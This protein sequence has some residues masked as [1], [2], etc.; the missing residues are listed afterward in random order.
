MKTVLF[1][2]QNGVGGAERMT[3]NIA[4]LLPSDKWKKIFC[5]ISFPCEVQNGRIDDFFPGGIQII[6]IYWSNQISFLRQMWKVL[7]IFKPDY[8]FSSVMPYNQRLLLLA[9]FFRNIKFIVRNDN[10]TFTINRIKRIIMGF[11]YRHASSIIAQTEEMKEELEKLGINPNKIQVLH[12]FIDADLVS[13]KASEESPFSKDDNI[14]FIS[15]GRVSDQK[16]FDIL[17]KAFKIVNDQ[18]PKSLLYIVGAYD[19]R[20]KGLYEQLQI[21]IRNLGL[22]DKVIFTGYDSNPYRYIRNADVYV[23]SS[24]YEGLPNVLIETQFLQT[25]AAATKCVPIISR[26]IHDGDN[27]YLALSEDPE[28]LA[29]AMIKSLGIQRYKTVYEPST[30]EEYVNLFKEK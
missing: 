3:V 23:L 19:G 5:K 16:G 10:Y 6:N 27:G 1:F 9:P 25:P 29:E 21:L 13:S 8:V 30:K 7:K 17:I 22:T 12:N 28:S 18:L 11:T 26:M 15:V 14:R 2:I 4:N 24:R 20:S